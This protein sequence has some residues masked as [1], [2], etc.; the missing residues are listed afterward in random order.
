MKF[1]A[2]L[3][4]TRDAVPLGPIWPHGGGGWLAGGIALPPSRLS[5]QGFIE[6]RKQRKTDAGRG[7][8]PAHKLCDIQIPAVYNPASHLEVIS[9]AFLRP[10]T[11]LAPRVSRP[12]YRWPH[13]LPTGWEGPMF[14]LTYS[15]ARSEPSTNMYRLPPVWGLAL[16][17]VG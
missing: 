3:A 16:D 9:L 4:A 5:Q 13:S 8:V 10:R 11:G 6:N 7:D 17:I 2:I 15:T 1:T 14:S 12:T